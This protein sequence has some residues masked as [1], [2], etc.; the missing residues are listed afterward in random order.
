MLVT[1]G[2][3]QKILA[4]HGPNLDLQTLH[5]FSNPGENVSWIMQHPNIKGT[6]YFLHEFEEKEGEK[7]KSGAISR[8][9]MQE[10][11]SL[12]MFEVIA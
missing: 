4:F 5:Q 1:S 12:F 11:G 7:E 9:V 10:D 6:F 2:Y 8:W 3:G